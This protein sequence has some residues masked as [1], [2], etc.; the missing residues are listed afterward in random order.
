MQIKNIANKLS[1]IY[2]HI[3]LILDFWSA[4]KMR[5]KSDETIA[6]RNFI[7]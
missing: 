2:K 3:G 6:M 4:A 1:E 5:C 7:L